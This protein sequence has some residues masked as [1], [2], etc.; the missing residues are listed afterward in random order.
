MIQTKDPRSPTEVASKHADRKTIPGKLS[1]EKILELF[2][3][4]YS[5]EAV[6]TPENIAQTYKISQK[7]AEDLVQYYSSFN[8][9]KPGKI[10]GPL[11]KMNLI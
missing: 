3:N 10:P 11:D 5:D 8:V 9:V 2:V 7:A 4:R 6:W 1:S